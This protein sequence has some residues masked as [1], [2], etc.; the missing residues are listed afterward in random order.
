MTSPTQRSLALL[1]SEGWTAQVVEQTIRGPGIT[2][3]RDLWGIGDILCLRDGETLL[4]QTTSGSHFTDRLAKIGDCEHLPE[5]R[6]AGWRIELHGWRK[7][8]G[9]WA[10]RREDCS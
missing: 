6:K 2:F 4:V 8:K 7:L 3:K 5:I 9:R 1:R 10:C